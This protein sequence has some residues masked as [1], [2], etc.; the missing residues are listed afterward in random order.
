MA[1]SQKLNLDVRGADGSTVTFVP[2][3]DT[4]TLLGDFLRAR[5]LTRD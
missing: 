3:G 2:S 4:R 1:A 5:S